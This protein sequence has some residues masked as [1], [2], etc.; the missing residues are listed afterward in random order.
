M[1]LACEGPEIEKRNQKGDQMTR[2]LV[3]LC[4]AVTAAPVASAS[5]APFCGEQQDGITREWVDM[6]DAA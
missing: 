6:A 3:A 5:G 1:H 4:V 2:L